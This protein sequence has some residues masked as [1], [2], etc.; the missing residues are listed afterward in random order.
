MIT[1]DDNLR[2]SE[3]IRKDL[4]SIRRRV[5]WRKATS[6][7]TFCI[8]FATNEKNLFDIYN[9]GEL[10]FEHYRRSDV[11]LHILGLADS[12]EEACELVAEMVKEVYDATGGLDVRKYFG[13]PNK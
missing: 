12:R 8:T 13:Q 1:W 9:M 7:T 6:A 4:R 11:D 3:R 10:L 2:C 5:R